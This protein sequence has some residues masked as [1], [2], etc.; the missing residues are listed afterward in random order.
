MLKS[1]QKRFLST[2]KTKRNAAFATLSDTDLQTFERMLGPKGLVTDEDELA[3]WQ[4]DW[5]Q[6]FTGNSKLM[7][8]PATTE[9]T[10]EVLKYCNQRK[11][12]VVPQGGNTG[13]VGANVP[14]FDEIIINTGRMNKILGFDDS[15][16]ILNAQAGCILSDL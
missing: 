6:K 3:P 8:K 5:S 11:L 16:G 13:L 14:V 10:A 9:E 4:I 1:I 12:A 7:L 2:L 15:Y